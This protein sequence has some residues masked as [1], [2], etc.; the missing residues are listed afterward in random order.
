M[1]IITSICFGTTGITPIIIKTL[2]GVRRLDV[3]S[4]VVKETLFQI[5]MLNVSVEK[6][7]VLNVVIMNVMILQAVRL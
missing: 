7:F 4:F 5:N 2:G 6:N 1:T 3:S